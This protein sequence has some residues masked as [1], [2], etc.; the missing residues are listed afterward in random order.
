MKA[1]SMAGSDVDN[2]RLLH[3]SCV[4][5][6]TVIENLFNFNSFRIGQLEKLRE[7]Y[8]LQSQRIRDNYTL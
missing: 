4:G 7:N 2:I 5:S 6:L 3:M 8:A 1:L